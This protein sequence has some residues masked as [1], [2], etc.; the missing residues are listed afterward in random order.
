MRKAVIDFDDVLFD[1]DKLIVGNK[2]IGT[3]YNIYSTIM[4]GV[5]LHRLKTTRF[6]FLS[7]FLNKLFFE[8]Y[9]SLHNNIEPIDGAVDG[10]KYI[11]S[12]GFEVIVLTT[13]SEFLRDITNKWVEKYLQECTDEIIY[14][15]NREP[16]CDYIKRLEPEIFV[17]D[18]IVNF[19]GIEYGKIK[20][21]ILYTSKWNKEYDVSKIN[22][23]LIR[24]NKWNEIR[25]I[26][27]N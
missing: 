2:S 19:N 3:K 22:K 26:L 4:R 12:L 27:C 6:K 21:P 11:K 13:R 23:K 8:K 10:I 5:D 25:F 17:D 15:N 20:Y 1:L 14:T 9:G 18:S 16:K 24:M 7:N